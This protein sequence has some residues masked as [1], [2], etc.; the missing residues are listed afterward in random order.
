MQHGEDLFGFHWTKYRKW[1]NSWNYMVGFTTF[2]EI[3]AHLRKC[4]VH[5]QLRKKHKLNFYLGGRSR[6]WNSFIIEMNYND[7][8]L[9]YWYNTW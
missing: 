5:T 1:L 4:K 3:E 6:T 9:T 7:K 8:D 2:I